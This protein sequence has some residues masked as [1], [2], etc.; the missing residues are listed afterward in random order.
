M[1]QAFSKC[2][3]GHGWVPRSRHVYELEG[4]ALFAE[5]PCSW[6]ALRFVPAS[7]SWRWRASVFHLQIFRNPVAR[8]LSSCLEPWI[9]RDNHVAVLQHASKQTCWRSAWLA[10]ADL[11]SAI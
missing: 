1:P 9:A 2:A 8:E 7:L 10:I 3:P 4:P 5:R 11:L 6:S